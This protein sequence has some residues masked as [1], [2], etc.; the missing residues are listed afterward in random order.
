[1]PP[2]RRGT[3]QLGFS[4]QKSIGRV[5]AARPRPAQAEPWI[6]DRQPRKDV[7]QSAGI[8]SD[9]AGAPV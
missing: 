5:G 8:V 1:M 7:L 3:G 2:I 9:S 6:A 4:L